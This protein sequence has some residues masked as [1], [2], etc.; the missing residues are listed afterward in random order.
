MKKKTRSILEEINSLAPKTSKDQILSYRSEN[1]LGG[2]IQLLEYIESNFDEK[3]QA[4]LR[5]RFMLSIK[6][7]DMGIFERGIRKIRKNAG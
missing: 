1:V 7:R 2:A 3:I 4:D 6:N 5:K